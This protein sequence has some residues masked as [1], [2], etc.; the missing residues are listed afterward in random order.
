[1]RPTAMRFGLCATLAA[2]LTAAG[3]GCDRAPSTR[4]APDTS[5]RTVV[6]SALRATQAKKARTEATVNGMTAGGRTF[7]SVVQT[8]LA[9][10]GRSRSWMQL[11]GGGSREIIV[12]G[13]RAWSRP[14][15]QATWTSVADATRSVAPRI[16]ERLRVGI[17]RGVLNVEMVRTADLD[18]RATTEYAV[19]GTVPGSDTG[20]SE[21][22]VWIRGDGLVQRC[23]VETH[24][25]ATTRIDETWT[26]DDSISI[27]SPER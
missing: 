3:P 19:T 26:Y 1:M 24:G 18:G 22:R 20:P 23:S 8:Q 2:A 6:L 10:P 9:P 27:E 25:T 21:A 16:D 12:I 7:E 15:K 5:A 4:T 13:D 14:S 17:E 11:P